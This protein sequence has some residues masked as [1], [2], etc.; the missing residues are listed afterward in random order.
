MT[1]QPALPLVAIS[2][3]APAVPAAER[4][5]LRPR[6]EEAADRLDAVALRP[7]DV[8]PRRADR[9]CAGWV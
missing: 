2:A 9:G 1:D 7:L 4:E 5:T 8:S 3:A 6:L